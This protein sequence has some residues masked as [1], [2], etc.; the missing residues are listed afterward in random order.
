[1][2]GGFAVTSTF[3]SSELKKVAPASHSCQHKADSQRAVALTFLGVTT[4][5]C[6][7]TGFIRHDKPPY[8]RLKKNEPDR[9]RVPRSRKN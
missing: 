3:F 6:F 5:R 7:R 4:Y 1:M 2:L 9:R 8:P